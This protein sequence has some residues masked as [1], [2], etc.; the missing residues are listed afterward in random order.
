MEQVTHEDY[1]KFVAHTRDVEI[2]RVKV[3]LKGHYHPDVSRPPR[4]VPAWN[5]DGLEF[6]GS[7]RLGN[8]QPKLPGQLV[9]LHST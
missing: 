5:Y 4:R 8:A 6:S 7:W 9:A 1:L 3:A 2:E